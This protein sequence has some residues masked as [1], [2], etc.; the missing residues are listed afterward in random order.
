MSTIKL[1]G[2]ID[3][4]VHLRDP[5][6]SHKEDFYTGTLAA[7][8]GGFTSIFDMP[9]NP[10]PITTKLR[11]D[12]KIKIAK[13]KTVSNLGFYFGSLGDN[14]GEFEKVKDLAW[15]L[16]LYLN[17]TTG[18]FIIDEKYLLNIYT[19]WKSPQPILLH[20]EEEMIQAVL[21]VVRKTGKKSHFCHVSSANELRQIIEAKEEGLPVSCGACAHHLFLSEDDGK[22]LGPYGTMKPPLK[23]KK[24]IEFLWKHIKYLD[25]VE[26][27]HAPHT[28]E[29]KDSAKPPFGVPGLET[30]LPLLLTAAQEGRISI[31]DVIRLCYDGPRKV[32]HIPA[33]D[34]TYI[35]VDVGSVYELKNE[36]LFTKCKWTPF[37]GWKVRGKVK[38]VT[39]KN[40]QVFAENNLLISPGEGTILKP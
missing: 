12:E 14:L 28:K 21:N 30:T 4:H 38:S 23:T 31:D 3:I 18:G 24:D 5:G 27:D 33:D 39:I 11:L 2:L 10:E 35:N 20:S 15:G 32:L 8:A 1:P 34:S 7:I 37:D 36:N 40:K 25:V 22:Q 19:A 16:K 26:S 9:N 13:E 6:Q 17:I 29:E